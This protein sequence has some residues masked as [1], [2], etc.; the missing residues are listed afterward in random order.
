M[1]FSPAPVFAL[2]TLALL[3][4]C[5]Q[6]ASVPGQILNIPGALLSAPGRL[7]GKNDDKK[8]EALETLAKAEAK[9]TADRMGAAA[10]GEVSYVDE[11]SGF[12]LIK[13]SSARVIPPSTPLLSKTLTGSITARL[14]ASPAAKGSFLA[15][16]IVSGTPERGNPILLD[17]EAKTAVE[18][19]PQIPPMADSPAQ[20]ANPTAPAAGHAA[21]RVAP[22]L[23]PILPPLEP[24]NEPVEV[25]E[26]PK[27]DQ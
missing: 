16:D 5:N 10:V 4:S 2:L 6:L 14:T 8:K 9:Q 27:L 7:L 1:K 25:P 22:K 26:L 11:E 12:I 24:L 3:P 13:R 15:A 20:T 17:P 23:E 21:P 19:I 18:T